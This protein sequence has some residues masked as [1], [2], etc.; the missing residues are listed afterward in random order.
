MTPMETA[1]NRQ[2]E[3]LP[4]GPDDGLPC[5]VIAGVQVYAYFDEGTLHVSVHYDNAE[6]E[7]VAEDGCVPTE[8]TIGAE[9]AWSG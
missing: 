7:V 3:F 2:A 1:L 8:V 4:M 6:P 5:L 9:K